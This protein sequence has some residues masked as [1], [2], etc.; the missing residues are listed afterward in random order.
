MIS[1][2]LQLCGAIALLLWAVRLIRT[3]VE[4]GFM[5]NLRAG[6]SK[7]GRSARTAGFGG[8]VAAF[9]LQS[10]TA[11]VLLIVSFVGSGALAPAAGLAVVLGADVGSALV[12][13]VLVR[14]VGDL[15]PILF[16]VGVPL[17]LKAEARTARE[18]GRIAIGLALVF[19]S[20]EMLRSATGP[21]KESILVEIALA[22]LSSDLVSG[23]FLGALLAWLMH[24]SVAAVLTLVTFVGA[25][26]LSVE[27]AAAIVMG[28]NFGGALIPY[29]LTRSAPRQS[30]LVVLGNIL[31]R[32]GGAGLVVL[33]LGVFKP[34]LSLLGGQP[35]QQVLNL[36][37]AFNLGIALLALPVVPAVLRLLE[38]LLPEA[39]AQK[40][41]ADVSALDET[42]LGNPDQA[43][44]CASREVLKMG[45]TVRGILSLSLGLYRNWDADTAHAIEIRE[46]QID[47]MHFRIKLYIARLQQG[48]LS[49][50]QSRQAMDMATFANSL[51]EAGDQISTNMLELAQQ[52]HNRG[53]EFSDKGWQELTEF[54]EQV[55][56]NSQLALNVLMTR[57]EDSALGV[58]E[59]KDRLRKLEKTM[60]IS[61]L[62][63]LRR[64]NPASIETSNLHQETIRSLKQVNTSFSI[65]AYPI[66]E[67][68]GALLSSRLTAR[69]G[70]G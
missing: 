18:A 69:S 52:M 51:E 20:L 11:V 35:M 15:I 14:P 59:A 31:L 38:N 2:G 19:I 4:R 12:A 37:L 29:A 9:G 25:G 53:F 1:F 68:A 5:A 49:E 44:A 62:E 70:R 56:G 63:R 8:A 65:M 30:R 22:Y 47:G 32:G 43:L 27:A 36:H 41:P 3:G 40:A 57:D 58:V 45:E 60:Q 54:H 23:F 17:F 28:A 61:H 26:L 21:L 66:A 67:E 55:V 50:S 42:A 33:G 39:A 13:Q 64:G 6:I 48:Q 24:S 7:A 46:Q 34:D 16:C 10:S